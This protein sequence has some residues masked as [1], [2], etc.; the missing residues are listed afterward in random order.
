M[1]EISNKYPCQEFALILLNILVL[2]DRL[3][4][5]F[6]I[7]ARFP[8]KSLVLTPRDSFERIMPI[9]Q[10]YIA[11]TAEQRKI[12]KK[13]G[14]VDETTRNVL[15]QLIFRLSKDIPFQEDKNLANILIDNCNLLNDKEL[16][17][18]IIKTSGFLKPANK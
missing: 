1:K 3:D 16:A 17:E 4:E 2:E 11:K 12:A 15:K 9:I 7:L 14:P 6:E 13:D 5:S 18:A 10:L 8:E